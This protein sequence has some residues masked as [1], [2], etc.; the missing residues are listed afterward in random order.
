MS[1]AR[2]ESGEALANQPNPESD[3]ELAKRLQ[4]EENRLAAASGNRP[5]STPSG[6]QQDDQAK[7]RVNLS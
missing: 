5:S 7:K 1:L 3:Y 6:Q 2:D 4:E